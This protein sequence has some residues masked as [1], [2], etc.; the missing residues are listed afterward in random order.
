MNEVLA[1][2]TGLLAMV[3]PSL[4][5]VPT[6]Q[7]AGYVEADYVYAAPNS[8]GVIDAFAVVEGQTV[9]RGAVLF[10]LTHAQQD[11]L[12][13]GAQARVAAA[14]ATAKNLA[15]GSRSAEVD[16]I[17]ASL[18]KAQTDLVLAQ[19]NLARSEK[20]DALG[21]TPKAKLDQDRATLASAQAQVDQL[22]AQLTVAELPARSGQQ[23]AAEA[24]LL[25][26]QADVDKAK[27]DLA[28]RT[29]VAPQDGVVDRLFYGRGEMVGAGMPVVSL[30]PAGAL[31]IKFYV[32][33]AA[34]PGFVLGDELAVSC[35]G[36]AT[37]ITAHV[38]RFA[39]DPQ[40][41]PPVIYSRD[42]RSRLVFLVEAVID[43]PG[44]LHPG[45]P[46]SVERA[47]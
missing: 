34:R 3:I 20:L 27:S 14:D 40:F 41:T 38:S 31:K 47:P 5:E 44:A 16:V 24:N 35:D 6:S 8:G 13:A 18:N 30:L 21:L 33:E 29:V 9:Q 46:V 39:A 36:C 23:L 45:Q 11:A 10:T 26:A 25:A 15:T 7:Y 19:T 17:R 1:F 28:D 37:G 2:F 32:D 43:A 4:G 42:E 12:L 22:S